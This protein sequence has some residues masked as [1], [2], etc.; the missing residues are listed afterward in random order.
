[1]KHCVLEIEAVE[2]EAMPEVM[3]NAF[4]RGPSGILQRPGM[5]DRGEVSESR[6]Q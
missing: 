6:I 3:A 5:R 2:L 4:E 1:M